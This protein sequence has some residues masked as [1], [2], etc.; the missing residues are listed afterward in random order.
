MP[1]PGSYSQQQQQPGLQT[2]GQQLG[3][4]QGSL[5]LAVPPS[6]KV[7]VLIFVSG[8]GY[9]WFLVDKQWAKL[10]AA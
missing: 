4:A 8:V 5:S 9:Q 6:G 7:P 10:Y 1:P 3:Q 2:Q